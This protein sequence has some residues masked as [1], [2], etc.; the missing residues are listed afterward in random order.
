MVF[1]GRYLTPQNICY[2][3]IGHSFGFLSTRKCATHHSKYSD[4]TMTYW[5][6][7]SVSWSHVLPSPNAPTNVIHMTFD[8]LLLLPKF[9]IFHA[10]HVV[11]DGCIRLSRSCWKWLERKFN[12]FWKW[13]ECETTR[14]FGCCSVLLDLPNT[15]THTHTHTHTQATK[16]LAVFSS[17]CGIH[18]RM[19][20]SGH[21]R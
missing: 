8:L 15:H 18:H 4:G 11:L 16:G 20:G 21:L 5:V 7:I 3:V 10:K 2:S 9:R 12:L 6:T 13:R 17:L 19:G 14:M 1:E